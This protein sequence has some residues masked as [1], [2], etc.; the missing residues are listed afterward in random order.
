MTNFDHDSGE[1][2]DTDGARSYYEITGDENSPDI[3]HLLK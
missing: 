1:Y 2:L 3:Y